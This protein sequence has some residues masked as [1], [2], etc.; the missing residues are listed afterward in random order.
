MT[1]FHVGRVLER[2]E[3]EGL[4]ENTL[5]VFFTD[6]GLVMPVASS[7]YMTKELIYLLLFAVPMFEQGAF[8]LIWSS[9]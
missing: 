8:E 3:T 4:L 6:H 9:I 7:F 2:L 1:D 5:V